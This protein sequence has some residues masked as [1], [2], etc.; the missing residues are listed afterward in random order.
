MFFFKQKIPENHIA[1]FYN[2]LA[3]ML[4]SKITLSKAIDILKEQ[5]YTPQMCSIVKDIYFNLMS[6]NS[7]SDSLG[8]F[9]E[10]FTESEINSIRASEFSDGLSDVLFKCSDLRNENIRLKRRFLTGVLYPL[11]IFSFAAIIFLIASIFVCNNLFPFIKSTGGEIPFF[12]SIVYSI[13]HF[14][15]NPFNIIT[16]IVFAGIFSYLFCVWSKSNKYHIDWLWWNIPIVGK[17]VKFKNYTRLCEIMSL[18]HKTGENI[19]NSLD[20]A[21][22]SAGNYT[23]LTIGSS[24][25]DSLINGESL[26]DASEKYFPKVMTGF[27]KMGEESGKLENS[28]DIGADFYRRESE[29][30][31]SAC[32]KMIEP[33]VTSFMGIIAGVFAGGLLTPIYNLVSSL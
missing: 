27:I 10:Y 33:L 21:S 8:K 13:C 30:A 15:S 2:H 9:P 28:F 5:Q 3:I 1:E 7:F 26:S 17:F 20:T 6:G 19:L 24:I 22:A 29:N 18:M 23:M 31:I 16:S 25:K 14:I 12:S 11:S 32:E 4:N